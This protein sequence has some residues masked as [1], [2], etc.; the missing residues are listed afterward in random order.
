LSYGTF[1]PLDVPLNEELQPVPDRLTQDRI[2]RAL[3]DPSRSK[4]RLT[5]RDHQVAGLAWIRNPTSDSYVF[6]YRPR[7]R[8]PVTGQRP[9]SRHLQLGTAADTALATARTKA[10]AH[11]AA[12]RAGEDPARPAPLHEPEPDVAGRLAE[13]QAA[14]V[15]VWSARHAGE[16]RRVL[17]REVIPVLGARPLAATRRA[18]WTALVAAKQAPAMRSLLY[19]ILAAFLGFAEAS[20]WIAAPLLPRRGLSTL[21]PVPEARERVLNDA[22]LVAVWHACAQLG[23]RSRALVRLLILTGARLSEVAG[24]TAT[25]IAADHWIVPANRTKNG[26]SY[27][28]PLG[29]LARSELAAVDHTLGN[30]SGFSKLK[31]QI[32]RLASVEQWRL[33]DLRRVVRTGLTRLGVHREIAEAAINHIGGRAGLVGTYDRHDYAAEILAAL[34]LWQ[35]HVAELVGG[36]IVAFARVG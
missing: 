29:A 9:G 21:A 26:K 36:N 23:P 27:T 35:D 5:L 2:D 11:K 30:Y 18:D 33:H 19:R 13:W 6:S 28:I 8:D 14:R 25:E 12:V 3:R 34:T 20:G 7:G 32:D 16:V 10:I 24:I 15:S 17:A 31:Q 1:V 22:E 4:G